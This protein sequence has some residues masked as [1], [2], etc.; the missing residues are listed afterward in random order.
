[1]AN[2]QIS[3]DGVTR[4]DGACIPPDPENRDWAAY[5]AWCDDGGIA[6]PEPEPTPGPG[7][8]PELI[9]ASIK[10]ATVADLTPE[11]STAAFPI[12]A[13]PI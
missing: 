6:D 8:D 9:S 1:M 12:I 5:L 3:G 7:P 2:Y 13:Q 11:E 4:N 10:I